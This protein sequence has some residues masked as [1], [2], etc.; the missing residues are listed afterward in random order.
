MLRFP[1]SC[2]QCLIEHKTNFN[3]RNVEINEEGIYEVECIN[4]HKTLVTLKNEK[5]EILFDMGL[6][7]FLD[8]YKQEAIA[9]IHASMERFHEWCI[10]I[11]L[12]DNKIKIS[13]FKKTWKYVKRQSER[14]LGAFYFLYLQTFKGVPE[15]FNERKT[16]FRNRVI[17]NGEIPKREEVYEYIDYVFHYIQKIL[18]PIK[19]Q[20]SKSINMIA[21]ERQAVLTKK[22]NTTHNSSYI[23]S[24]LGLFMYGNS[25]EVLLEKA[26]ANIEQIQKICKKGS[27]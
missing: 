21:I 2:A 16:E 20:M 4:G 9:C 3:F 22:Y 19:Q 17:H 7:A 1:V 10:E 11:F 6:S 15:L 18:K 24:G 27:D 25:N 8:G 12:I 5:F 14:Q 26:I 23:Q 13:D